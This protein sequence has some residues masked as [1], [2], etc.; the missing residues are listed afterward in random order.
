M[1]PDAAL[2]GINVAIIGINALLQE[3]AN[4]KSQSGLTDD[5]IADQFAAHG[6]ATKAAISGYLANLPA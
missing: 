1:T 6:A 3:I 2:A 4:L 5:Q